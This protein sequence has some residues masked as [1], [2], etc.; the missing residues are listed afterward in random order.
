MNFDSKMTSSISTLDD[1]R[2]AGEEL[3]QLAVFFVGSNR[4][5]ID[6]MRIKR[7]IQ[8]S[9][10]PILRIPLAPSIVE[11]VITLRGVVIP[12]IDLRH[13]F[14]VEIDPS[15]ERFNK[16]IIISVRGHIVSFKVDRVYGE[17]RIPIDTIRPAPA[18]FAVD[19]SGAKGCFSGICKTAEGVVFILD[20]DRL[21]RITNSTEEAP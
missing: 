17:I 1:D 20:T 7:V 6:I 2:V 14:G 5:G 18:L 21:T 11:G 16:L 13:R 4:Y 8:A 10:Y 9:P 3:L 15:I 12:V 19:H